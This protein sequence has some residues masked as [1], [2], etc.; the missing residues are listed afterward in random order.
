MNKIVQLLNGILLI[1]LAIMLNG[2]AISMA[3]KDEFIELESQANELSHQA[4]SASMSCPGK[5]YSMM[6]FILVP[7]PPIIPTYWGN[8][9][10][11]YLYITAPK[12]HEPNISITNSSGVSILAITSILNKSENHKNNTNI[13]Y[14]F[15]INKD[16]SELD[17]H[18]INIAIGN[19]T[20]TY[21]I[22]YSDGKVK[23]EWAYLS[24]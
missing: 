21:Y 16:C 12:D 22:K 2:C 3:G 18:I 6:A 5:M 17:G 10:L 4:L 7:L 9:E 19:Q 20:S 11:S 14:Y 15:H 1:T 13:D 8:E 24:A 23:F